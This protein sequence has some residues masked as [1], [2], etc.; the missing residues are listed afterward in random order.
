MPSARCRV[1]KPRSE[2]LARTK[3]KEGEEL[4]GRAEG[5]GF[6]PQKPWCSEQG[7]TAPEAPPAGRATLLASK[8]HSPYRRRA[9]LQPG[10]QLQGHSPK[11]TISE[12][13]KLK[14]ALLSAQSATNMRK[15]SLCQPALEV[16]EMSSQESS[17]E[18]QTDKDDDYMDI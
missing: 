14:S 16:L 7:K 13:T 9:H 3:K 5:T 8:S 17:L 2:D 11:G 1:L 12:E 18:S 6:Q 10:R 15:E 4:G